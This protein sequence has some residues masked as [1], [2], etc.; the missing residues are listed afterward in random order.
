VERFD[1]GVQALNWFLAHF[2]LAN[3]RAHA[4][5]IYKVALRGDAV[6]HLYTLVV[7]EVSLEQ[8]PERNRKG[9]PAHHPILLNGCWPA[10]GSGAGSPGA[11]PWRRG[12]LKVTIGR[13]L[14]AADIAGIQALAAYTAYTKNKQARSFDGDFGFR[15]SPS[16]PLHLLALLKDLKIGVK[17]G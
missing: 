16:D 5:R 7:G 14:A 13:S 4:N 6:A 9:A 8:A 1:C 17:W 11:G 15:P 3:Q 12:L 10:A 2:A